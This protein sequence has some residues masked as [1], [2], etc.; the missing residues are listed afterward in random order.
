MS[1]GNVTLRNPSFEG[2]SVWLASRGGGESAKNKRSF[3]LRTAGH[4]FHPSLKD[5]CQAASRR[6]PAADQFNSAAN[7]TIGKLV[8]E[9]WEKRRFAPSSNVFYQQS[10]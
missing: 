6:A 2:S 3:G 4:C 7:I 5:C 8:V 10:T 9:S 1:S